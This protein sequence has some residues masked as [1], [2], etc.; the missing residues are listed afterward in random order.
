MEKQGANQASL[1]ADAAA[2]EPEVIDNEPIDL[3]CEVTILD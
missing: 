3:P 2:E 1:D